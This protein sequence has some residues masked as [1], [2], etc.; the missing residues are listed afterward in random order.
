MNFIRLILILFCLL[1]LCFTA[2]AQT[3]LE[4]AN[5]RL[6]KTLDTLEK[7]EK[8]RDAY[9]KVADAQDKVIDSQKGQIDLLKLALKA[10]EEEVEALRSLKCNKTSW[11]FGLV[12]VTKCR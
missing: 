11:L 2:N 12:K 10:R 3:P 9:V 7:T 8:E 4:V 1:W 5:Q 6:A